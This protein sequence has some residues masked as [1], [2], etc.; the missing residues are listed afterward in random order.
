MIHLFLVS[1]FDMLDK[2]CQLVLPRCPEYHG[3]QKSDM[4]ADIACI[5]KKNLEWCLHIQDDSNV[6][7]KILRIGAQKSLDFKRRQLDFKIKKGNL[8]RHHSRDPNKID[9]Y[10]LSVSKSKMNS[11]VST[12]KIQINKNQS[13]CSNDVTLSS[14]SAL[15]VFF[16]SEE[17]K[18]P[19]TGLGCCGR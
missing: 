12:K 3:P 9:P 17:R 14:H 4:V 7:I 11:Y 13:Y 2:Q 18:S 15:D 6:P 16:S 1:G 10:I 8:T 5:L 19:N